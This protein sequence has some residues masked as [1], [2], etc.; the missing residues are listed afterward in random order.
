MLG[1]IDVT[2]QS[3]KKISMEL[4]PV[5]LDDL[6]LSAAIEW[7]TEEFRKRTGIQCKVKVLPDENIIVEKSLATALFRMLQEALTNV[8]RHANATI[9]NI[10]LQVEADRLIMEIQDN[11][12]GI[13]ESKISSPKAFGILGMRERVRSLGG[14][15]LIQ[16]HPGRGTRIKV[17]V[18]M[19]QKG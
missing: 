9:V 12:K 3:V 13:R 4:R 2:I 7:Y 15:I 5:I 18:P 1:L 6:G 11:G 19:E 8:A 10:D 16:G 14:T 17:M